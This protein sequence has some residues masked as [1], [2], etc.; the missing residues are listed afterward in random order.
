MGRPVGNGLIELVDEKSS[1]R[2]FFCM[3]LVGYLNEEREI[4]TPGYADLWDVR[5]SQAKAGQC[6]YRDK[7]P[8][9]ARTVAKREKKPLQLTINF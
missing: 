1:E 5:F 9:H 8:I 6:A 2:G 4:G 3:Q 7:C